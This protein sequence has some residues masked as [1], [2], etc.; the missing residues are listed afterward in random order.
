MKNMATKKNWD[1]KGSNFKYGQRDFGI[2]LSFTVLNRIWLLSLEVNPVSKIGLEQVWMK[3]IKEGK[4]LLVNSKLLLQVTSRPESFCDFTD[5]KVKYYLYYEIYLPFISPC[6][7]SRQLTTTYTESS[8]LPNCD[9]VCLL[10]NSATKSWIRS[11]H[12]AT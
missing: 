9:R 2:Y 3:L 4:N 10:Q 1:L 6:G 8:C 7:Y 12:I 5:I 11:E